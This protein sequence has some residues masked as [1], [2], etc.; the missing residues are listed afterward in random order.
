M[1]SGARREIEHGLTEFD[2][3][4]D[5]KFGKAAFGEIFMSTWSGDNLGRNFDINI[6]EGCIRGIP[7]V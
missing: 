5:M 4:F 6:W 3:N 1:R 7:L 2:R